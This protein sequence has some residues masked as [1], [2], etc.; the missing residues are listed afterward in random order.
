MVWKRGILS[1]RSEQTMVVS[2]VKGTG[3]RR[4]L[5]YNHQE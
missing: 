4:G 1:V 3:N 2:K 5:F